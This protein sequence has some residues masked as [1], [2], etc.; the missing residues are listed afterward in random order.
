[1]SLLVTY[2]YKRGENIYKEIKNME[3]EEGKDFCDCFSE[4]IIGIVLSGQSN[5]IQK[6]IEKSLEAKQ[7]GKKKEINS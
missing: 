1:M 5:S 6:D 2:L 3:E 7:P 4:T